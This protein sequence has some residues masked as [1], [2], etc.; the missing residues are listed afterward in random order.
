MVLGGDILVAVVLRLLVLTVSGGDRVLENA[1][2]FAKHCL[3]FR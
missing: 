3:Q 2:R 1:G